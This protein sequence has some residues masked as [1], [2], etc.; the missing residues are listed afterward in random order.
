MDDPTAC[1]HRDLVSI[2]ALDPDEDEATQALTELIQ[3]LRVGGRPPDQDEFQGE[4]FLS[5][6]VIREPLSVISWLPPWVMAVLGSSHSII[7]SASPRIEGGISIPN[8][9]AVLRLTDNSNLVGCATGKS[10]GLAPLRIRA[11]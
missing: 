8:A 5:A 1:W 6:S 9:F 7:L 2:S 3:W 10:A 4:Y 11:T